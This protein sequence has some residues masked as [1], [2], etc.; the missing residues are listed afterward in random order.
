MAGIQP[1]EGLGASAEHASELSHRR[2]ERTG[3]LHTDRTHPHQMLVEGYLGD[4]DSV[5]EY[6]GETECP[7]PPG[8]LL[9]WAKVSFGGGRKPPGK[10]LQGAGRWKS[11]TDVI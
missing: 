7:T 5:G 11:S 3:Y 4:V 6:G 1:A 8:L 2:D 9:S 10:E